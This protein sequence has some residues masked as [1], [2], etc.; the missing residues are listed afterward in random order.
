MA[1]AC[2]AVGI[3]AFDNFAQVQNA[4]EIRQ[5]CES[6]SFSELNFLSCYSV[7]AIIY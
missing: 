6:Y 3:G 1:A 5:C 4:I 2:S 7:D